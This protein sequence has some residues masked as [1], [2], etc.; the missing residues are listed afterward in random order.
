MCTRESAGCM[1]TSE[2]A[3]CMCT[4]ESAG[5]MVGFSPGFSCPHADLAP[6][7]F[8]ATSEP[9]HCQPTDLLLSAAVPIIVPF[10]NARA[11]A[12]TCR[13]RHQMAGLPKRWLHP[14]RGGAT[15]T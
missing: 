2:S 12:H 14:P 5:C 4:S 11:Y 9:S 3:G 10:P 1:C 6:T 13:N 7:T 8:I 15:V